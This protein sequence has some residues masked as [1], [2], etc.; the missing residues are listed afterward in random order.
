MQDNVTATECCGWVTRANPH[1]VKEKGEY[2]EY[3]LWHF[4]CVIDTV[5]FLLPYVKYLIITKYQSLN[6]GAK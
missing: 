5:I 6:Y 2:F 1:C 3:K 4:N